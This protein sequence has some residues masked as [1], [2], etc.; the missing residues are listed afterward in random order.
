[1]ASWILEDDCLAPERYV[2]IVYNGPNPFQVY[3]SSYAIFR[4]VMEIDPADYQER[5][6]RWDITGDPR[7]FYVRVIV[8]KNL[9]ARSSIYFEI[10]MQGKQPT[11]PSQN[12]TLTILIGAKLKTE[13]ALNTPFQQS[14]FYRALLW[15]Y[16]R[17]FYFGVRRR[18]IKMCNDWITNI[19][20]AYRKLLKLE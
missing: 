12:G 18:Y 6:F 8:Q 15:L 19:V 2:R 16:N 13:Y 1:M 4:K 9:D 5:E 10:I 17:F 11:D 7:D 14:S 20:K 3:Q